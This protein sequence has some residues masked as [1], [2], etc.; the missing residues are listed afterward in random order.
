MGLLYLYLALSAHLLRLKLCWYLY[1][2]KEALH[3]SVS[4]IYKSEAHTTFLL[5]NLYFQFDLIFPFCVLSPAVLYM[6]GLNSL[7]FVKEIF[8]L[9]YLQRNKII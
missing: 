2:L 8:L 7:Q 4:K 6:L 5:R 3:K 1:Q 9:W